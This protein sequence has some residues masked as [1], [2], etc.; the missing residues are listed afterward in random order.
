MRMSRTEIRQELKQSEGDPHTK[1][2]IRRLQREISRRRMMQDVP[3][4]TVVVTNPTH[5]AVALLYEQG[6]G[7]PKVLA[8]GRD[9]VARRIKEI[10]HKNGVPLV[11]NKP[12]AQ[13][14]HKNV[15]IGREIS[16][17]LYESVAQVLAFV[18]RTYGR[19]SRR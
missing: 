5:Y 18:Y 12:L 9:E 10:A 3:K 1:N 8:K 2:R 19:R 11:E 7:A 15:E 6:M 13:A 16:G 17:D 14:L 4:A